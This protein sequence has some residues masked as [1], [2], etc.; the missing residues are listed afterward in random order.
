MKPP[1]KPANS[2]RASAYKL[3]S[4]LLAA[5][6]A[7]IGAGLLSIMVEGIAAQGM[8]ITC[9]KVLRCW[10][11]ASENPGPF[12]MAVAMFSLLG[13]CFFAYGVVF[14]YQYLKLRRSESGPPLNHRG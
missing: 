5:C 7:L 8:F 1:D 13:I 3:I 12:W 6:A 10:V 11:S 14:A 4:C 9:R 2:I